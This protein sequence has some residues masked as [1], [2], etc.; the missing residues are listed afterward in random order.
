MSKA[1]DATTAATTVEQ[2]KPKSVRQR[3][4]AYPALDLETAI[5][6]ARSFYDYEKRNPANLIVAFGHWGFKTTSGGGMVCIAALKYFGLMSD[7]GSGAKRIVQLTELGA[8]IVIDQRPV[9]P[10]RDQAIKEAALRPKLHALLWRKYGTN[11][12]SDANLRHELVFDHRFNENSVGDFIQEYK[13]T[14]RFAKLADSDTLS[15]ESEDKE[16]EG[17]ETEEEPE[18]PEV[19]QQEQT[20]KQNQPPPGGKIIP[21]GPRQDVFSLT[22]GPVTIQWPAS[23]SPESYEDLADWLDIVKRKIGRSVSKVEN[24][25]RADS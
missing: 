11:L 2:P 25:D 22:E 4:P 5:K 15:V 10:E 3:S 12:P 14:I 19:Q 21:P 20:I 8:R 1:T 24:P 7:S 9:S 23:L 13:D 16:Q 6:R 18:V 17:D